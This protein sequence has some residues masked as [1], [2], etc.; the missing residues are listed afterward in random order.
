MIAIVISVGLY[1][2]MRHTSNFG[3]HGS[4]PFAFYIG[5]IAVCF[6]IAFVFVP[7]AIFSLP[8]GRGGC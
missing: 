8:N 2:G 5:A 1:N 3:S 7:E 4:K 6:D